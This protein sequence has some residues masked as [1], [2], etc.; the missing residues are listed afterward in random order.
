AGYADG[1]I[2]EVVMQDEFFLVRAAGVGIKFLRVVAGAER[3][4]RDGLRFAAG[5]QRGTVR[6][7]QNAHF[8]GNRTNHIKR[9]TV[10][11]L[12]AFEDQLAHGFFLDVVKRVVDDE[13]RDFFRTE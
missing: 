12:A 8:A 10:E 1:E 4:E 7:R 9:T 6:A 3:G 2:G 13:L 5:E 11:T